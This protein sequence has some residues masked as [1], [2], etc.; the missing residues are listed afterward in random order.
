MPELY[1]DEVTAQRLQQLQESLITLSDTLEEI[2][3][4]L[5]KGNEPVR[6]DPVF[7]EPE[8]FSGICTCV[9]ER[10]ITD[11]ICLA[12]NMPILQNKEHIMID[13]D[14]E[15]CELWAHPGKCFSLNN[16]KCK[17]VPAQFITGL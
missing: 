17:E 6:L 13:C 4:E 1:L 9:H 12:C 11:G 3:K 16:V 5:R 7:K 8:I 15:N 2:V 14:L 10:D